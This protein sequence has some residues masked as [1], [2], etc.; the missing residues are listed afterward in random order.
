MPSHPHLA[1]DTCVFVLLPTFKIFTCFHLHSPDITHYHPYFVWWKQN[2]P[3]KSFCKKKRE[4][5]V[6]LL[7]KFDQISYVWVMKF[8]SIFHHLLRMQEIH[9]SNPLV[10]TGICDPNKS[11][12]QHHC[13]LKL[14]LR[15]KYLNIIW[16]TFKDCSLQNKEL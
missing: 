16:H 3:N 10:V 9:S 13:S 11:W 4:I 6:I 2:C 1:G 8:K 7:S 14:G 15:L 5:L 12:A